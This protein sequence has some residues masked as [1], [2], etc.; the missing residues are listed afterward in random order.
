MAIYLHTLNGSYI[1]SSGVS[2]VTNVLNGPIPT[3]VDAAME[4][5]YVVKGSREFTMMDVWELGIIL[6]VVSPVSISVIL[7]V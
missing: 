7:I 4:H 3:A 2:T 6:C 5:E 1:P